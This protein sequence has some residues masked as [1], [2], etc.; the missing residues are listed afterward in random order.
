[1]NTDNTEELKEFHTDFI[2]RSRRVKSVDSL[3]PITTSTRKTKTNISEINSNPCSEGSSFTSSNVLCGETENLTTH[4]ASGSITTGSLSDNTFT[5]NANAKWVPKTGSVNP[6]LNGWIDPIPPFSTLISPNRPFQVMPRPPFTISA[7][8]PYIDNG[9]KLLISVAEGVPALAVNLETENTFLDGWIDT[10]NYIRIETSK[11]LMFSL[12][13]LTK[14]Y[15][16]G[17]I[18][19]TILNEFRKDI[20]LA[21][22]LVPMKGS[23][24]KSIGTYIVCFKRD[25]WLLF[26]P[27]VMMEIIF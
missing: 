4:T 27:R 7:P 19:Q 26:I 17:Q 13:D 18:G 9:D 8:T 3:S 6:F 11:E 14:D 12:S 24:Y 1:M 22:Y 20:V 5:D 10:V 23:D 15:F 25:R 2:R 21:E 16:V